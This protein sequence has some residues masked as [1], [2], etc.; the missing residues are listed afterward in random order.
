MS[1]AF[2]IVKGGDSWSEDRSQRTLTE[3]SLAGGD[4]SVVTYPANP[5]AGIALRMQ[6]LAADDP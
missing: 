6:Q 2:G 3:L 1:F 4:V 5:N